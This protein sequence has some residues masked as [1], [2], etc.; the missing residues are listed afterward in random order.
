MRLCRVRLVTELA[1]RDMTSQDLAKQAGVSRA[2]ISAI[3]NGRSCSN[4]TAERIAEVLGLSVEDLTEAAT[5]VIKTKKPA[6]T[7]KGGLRNADE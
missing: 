4:G 6:N 7:G 2:T 1:K 3:K 5:E